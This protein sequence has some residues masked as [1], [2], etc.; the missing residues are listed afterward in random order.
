VDWLQ[1]LSL[2]DFPGVYNH[3]ILPEW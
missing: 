1:A 2:D 3:G